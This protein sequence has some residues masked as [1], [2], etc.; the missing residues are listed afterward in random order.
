MFAGMGLRVIEVRGRL[1]GSAT[2]GC[3]APARGRLA[4]GWYTPRA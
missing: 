1:K 4:P 3:A 2:G